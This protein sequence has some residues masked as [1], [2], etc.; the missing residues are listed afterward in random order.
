M[1]IRYDSLYHD[2]KI[3]VS[4]FYSKY[5]LRWNIKF[6]LTHVLLRR[7]TPICTTRTFGKIL[8]KYVECVLEFMKIEKFDV[9]FATEV[10]NTKKYFKPVVNHS[11][12]TRHLHP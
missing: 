12:C 8:F 7:H 6:L 10:G 2:E 1:K 4:R 3:K 11:I 5:Y 9:K